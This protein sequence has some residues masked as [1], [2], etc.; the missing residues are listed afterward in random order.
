V[1]KYRRK[2]P[3]GKLRHRGEDKI[4]MDHKEIG[5]EGTDWIY[6]AED[7]GKWWDVL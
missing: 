1:E 5:L 3:Y 7:M 2:R 6:L 4:N